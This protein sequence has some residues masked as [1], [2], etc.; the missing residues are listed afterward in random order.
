GADNK[1]EDCVEC[2]KPVAVRQAG[3]RERGD[4]RVGR[5]ETRRG[6][7]TAGQHKGDRGG[8][9]GGGPPHRGG[10]SVRGLPPLRRRVGE[11]HFGDP[12]GATTSPPSPSLSGT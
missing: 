6:Q 9:R 5:S 12:T 11:A 3:P 10:A 8:E 7:R 1:A 2:G 4:Q